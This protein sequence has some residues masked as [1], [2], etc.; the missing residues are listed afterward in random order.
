M[1]LSGNQLSWFPGCFYHLSP[2]IWKENA[3][4]TDPLTSRP[5]EKVRFPLPYSLVPFCNLTF[6]SLEGPP[7]MPQ[8]MD[9]KNNLT[10]RVRSCFY[11]LP[12]PPGLQWTCLYENTKGEQD[13]ETRDRH[14][15]WEKCPSSPSPSRP[16]HVLVH[17][18]DTTTEIHWGRGQDICLPWS[19]NQLVVAKEHYLC[20]CWLKNVP[21]ASHGTWLLTCTRALRSVVQGT[22]LNCCFVRHTP[23]PTESTMKVISQKKWTL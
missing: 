9:T 4:F 18:S 1:G 10:F 21:S 16:P 22:F 8:V 15:E 17:W 5:R 12:F 13:V 3:G 11:L 2:A 19:T 20:S 6:L 7:P 23:K 14:R